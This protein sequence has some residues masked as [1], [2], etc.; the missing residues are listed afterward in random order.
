M[1]S[2]VPPGGEALLNELERTT[3]RLSGLNPADSAFVHDA[4]AERARAI[5]GFVAWIAACQ[6]PFDPDPELTARIEKALAAGAQLAVR[7]TLVRAGLSAQI[8]ELGRGKRLLDALTRPGSR[9]QLRRARLQWVG[10]RHSCFP[11]AIPAAAIVHDPGGRHA[12]AAQATAIDIHIRGGSSCGAARQK[13]YASV[14][15]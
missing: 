14:R 5:E 12:A 15:R 8:A 4:L 9:R 6:T 13:P 7:L 1:S 10:P 11:A 3:A 2:P